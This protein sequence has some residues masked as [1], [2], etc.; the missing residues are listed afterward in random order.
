MAIIMAVATKITIIRKTIP[1]PRILFGPFLVHK[2]HKQYPIRRMRLKRTFG[3]IVGPLLMIF[4]IVLI[5]ILMRI[6]IYRHQAS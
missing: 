4:L 1:V 6:I 5:G 3:P 2:P